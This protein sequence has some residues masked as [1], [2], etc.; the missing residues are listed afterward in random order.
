MRAL[1]LLTALLV[2]CSQ[3][4]I[5]PSRTLLDDP[6]VAALPPGLTMIGGVELGE[7]D[8]SWLAAPFAARM[9]VSPSH[10]PQVVGVQGASAQRLVLGCGDHGC[11]A[12][13]EGELEQ[14]D[15][16]AV[17]DRRAVA[18]PAAD[19]R[20]SAAH[21][22]GLDA[23]LPS[24][25]TLAL[26]Q[27]SP[28]KLVLGDRAAVRSAYPLAPERG[29]APDPVRFDPAPL[30]GMVPEGALWL[31]AHQPSR[32]ALQAARRLEQNGSSAA[33]TMAV[34][35]R[36]M[37]DCCSDR[38][39]DVV[40]VALAVDDSDGVTAVLR[41]TCRDTWTARAVERALDDR[42]ARALDQSTPAWLA[43]LPSL[44]LV[45]AG[46]VVELRGYGDQADLEGLL[47]SLEVSP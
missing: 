34:E 42:L 36:N 15:W 2:G 35:L 22:P 21:E 1:A 27:L 37:V 14:V 18:R 24:G 46:S 23:T 47:T 38:L 30:E 4:T 9:G 32:M 25:E 11:L 20:C 43:A 10:A 29:A 7:L 33:T 17:A 45:R 5:G 28:T 6:M 12:L 26:R 40:A 8:E 3:P 39:E 41:V 44:E 13:A 16:C 19:F 31:V